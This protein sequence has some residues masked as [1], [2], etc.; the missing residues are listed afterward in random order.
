M[1]T[2]TSVINCKRYGLNSASI[3][4]MVCME[5]FQGYYVSNYWPAGP[6]STIINCI[7]SC[8]TSDG[9]SILIIDDFN[10]FINI[11]V[12]SGVVTTKLYF[13][14]CQKLAR[15]TT[16]DNGTISDFTCVYPTPVY[17]SIFALN[18]NPVLSY[19]SYT[20]NPTSV[21]N[22]DTANISIDFIHGYEY[23]INNELIPAVFNNKGISF[24]ILVSS[25]I[26]PVS[27]LT[28]C[29]LLFAIT[30]IAS[31]FQTNG[32]NNAGYLSGSGN[33]FACSRCNFGY[34]PVFQVTT[35]TGNPNM[36][37]CQIITSGCA[38]NTIILG[39]LSSFI[40]ASLSC[41]SCTSISAV[42]Y[43]PTIY[44]EYDATSSGGYANFI[45]YSFPIITNSVAATGQG[46]RCSQIPST[47]A[48]SSAIPTSGQQ[49]SQCAVFGVLSAQV[50]GNIDPTITNSFC[51]SC[52]TG[53]YPIYLAVS[54]TRVTVAPVYAPS[55]IVTS[56]Q[57][58]YKCDPNS[59]VRPFNS[60]GR[61][62]TLEQTLTPPN[63]YAF[64]DF[65]LIN[66]LP[67]TSPN[68]FIIAPTSPSTTIASICLICQSGFY[69]NIDSYCE[70]IIIPN[71]ATGSTFISTFFGRRK[72]AFPGLV[73]AGF[74]SAW[75]RVHYLLSYF[76]LQY[77]AIDCQTGYT[78]ASPSSVTFSFCVM[79]NYLTTGSL[80]TNSNFIA[81]CL[82][83]KY[84]AAVSNAFQCQVCI[85][86]FIPNS[87]FNACV[88]SVSNCL[89]AITATPTLCNACFAGYINL[90]GVCSKITLANCLVYTNT[91][92]YSTSSLSCSICANGFYALTVNGVTTCSIGSVINCITYS[93]GSATNCLACLSNYNLILLSN[94]NLYCYPVPGTFINCQMIINNAGIGSV[95]GFSQGYI[96]CG[97]CTNT[98][99]SVLIPTL[100]TSLNT[101]IQPQSLCMQFAQVANCLTYDQVSI[102]FAANSFNCLTCTI[103]YYYLSSN[104]TCMSRL[105]LDTNCILFTANSDTCNTCNTGFFLNTL[106][107]SC[108]IFPNGVQSC[109]IYA[110]STTCLNC[111]TGYYLIN[112]TCVLSTPIDSC[113]SYSANYTCMN[114]QSPYF[115]QNN[116]CVYATANNCLTYSNISA[117]LTC[118]PG[119]GLSPTSTSIDC[120]PSVIPNC[121]TNTNVFPFV[122]LT[123]ATGYYPFPDGTCYQVP[124]IIASCVV[125]DTNVT[126]AKC[127][128]SSVLAAS[129]TY[130]DTF[131]YNGLIDPKCTYSVVNP[132]PICVICNTAFY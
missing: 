43:Y 68:C 77:G 17:S 131:T 61:C 130:C 22:M 81:N 51:L 117:C 54:G 25:I 71:L 8:S 26:L 35:A 57:M 98:P 38:S 74:D 121:V 83:Y 103:N 92:Q 118:A 33:L 82:K 39:G 129:K 104:N 55:Y 91:V 75:V 64:S 27:S 90:S 108:I 45:Q 100:W 122:C 6:A 49:V 63:Y 86:N 19:E 37:V 60:C 23:S 72:A 47:V 66:C 96:N 85:S 126:C 31:V 94:N 10:G 56:C 41:H 111:T 115:L 69:L 73:V 89:F 101:L 36:P 13:P 99:T 29:D 67:V 44:M 87:V 76:N 113:V 132:N 102:Y 15:T 12:A 34:Q 24:S 95:Y 110:N 109:V 46:F 107:T 42:N 1:S 88:A 4:V 5:C 70:S 21:L 114:C 124:Q 125:Y 59:L 120:V 50:T 30:S 52:L 40:H 97:S 123:C 48:I 106:S 20:A 116:T 18:S 16:V 112:N 7:A 28:N 128:P 105:N 53:Y 79:S 9:D 65:R 32:A 93:Y 84:A 2:F 58:S 11:C 3:P 62:S 127:S 78:K 119:N 80:I 14:G